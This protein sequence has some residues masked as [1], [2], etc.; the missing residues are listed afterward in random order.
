MV[1]RLHLDQDGKVNA[2]HYILLVVLIAVIYAA[3]M[4]VPPYIQFMTIKKIAAET[5]L[6]ASTVEMNDERNKTWYDSRMKEE[7]YEYPMA[8]DLYY[9]RHSNENVEIGFEYDYPVKHLWGTVHVLHFSYTC[10]A[11]LGHCQ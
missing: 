4:Y 10:N 7:R 1:S 6:S 9:Q 8:Q 11:K 3:V 2:V 5:A